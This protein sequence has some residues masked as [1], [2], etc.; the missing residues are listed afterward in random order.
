MNKALEMNKG[1]RALL[2]SNGFE[3]YSIRKTKRMVGGKRYNFHGSLRERMSNHKGT[4][5]Y[6]YKVEL[7]SNSVMTNDD[8][9]LAKL[10]LKDAGYNVSLDNWSGLRVYI[11]QQGGTS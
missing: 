4:P 8:Y 6:F 10:I 3:L 7:L 2:E 1:I 9:N 5:Q 11:N